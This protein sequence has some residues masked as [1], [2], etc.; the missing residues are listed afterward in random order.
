M[1]HLRRRFLEGDLKVNC[2]HED[3]EVTLWFKDRL[4]VLK[5]EALKKKILDEAHMSRYS[6]HPGSTKIYHNLRQQFWC[7]E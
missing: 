3:A 4:V 2:F 1:A 7:Q 6:I 5:E